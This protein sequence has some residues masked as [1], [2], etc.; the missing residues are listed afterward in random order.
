MNDRVTLRHLVAALGERLRLSWVCGEDAASAPIVGGPP[1]IAN[2]P[3]IGGLNLI[4]PNRIQVIGH[5]ELI[6]LADLGSNSFEDTLAQL[7]SAKPC[8]IL[9]GDDIKVDDDLASAAQKYDVP[10]LSSPVPDEQLVAEIRYFL[11]AALA[12]HV[13]AHGVFMEVLGVGVLITGAAGIGKSELA[14]ELITRGHRLVADDAPEFA[15]VAPGILRGTCPSLLCNFL[16]VRGLGI[17]NIRALFGDAAIKSEKNLRLIVHLQKMRA[18][19]LARVDRLEGTHSFRKVLGVE[20]PQIDVP[21][22]P[23]RSL[24]ILVEVAVRNHMLRLK[25]YRASDDFT[26]RQFR[27]VQSE[28]SE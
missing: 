27:L 1:E 16:E 9:V 19:Q 14:L 20:V 25:G 3:L 28:G 15:H 7:F 2:Q 12:E 23:G 17:L 11:T 8:A 4:H 18:E 22:A 24:A 6:F 13:T 21:V 5:L 10:I 26:E